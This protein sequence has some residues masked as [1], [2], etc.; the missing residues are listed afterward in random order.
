MRFIIRGNVLTRITNKTEGG[1]DQPIRSMG[2]V[3][4]RSSIDRDGLKL[5]NQNLSTEEHALSDNGFTRVIRRTG[6]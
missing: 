4:S 2:G 5:G 6:L 1:T 3:L